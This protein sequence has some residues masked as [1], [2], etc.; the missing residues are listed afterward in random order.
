MDMVSNIMKSQVAPSVG[1]LLEEARLTRGY[2]LDD[3]AETTGLTVAEVTALENDADFDASRI[4]RTASAL[5]ILEK[6][7][8]APR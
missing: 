4:R 3:L 2:S 8:D 6:I 7:C 1:A 5:G